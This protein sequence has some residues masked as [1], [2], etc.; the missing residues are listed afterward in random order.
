MSV[1]LE[2]RARA[3]VTVNPD[4]KPHS[5]KTIVP[6]MEIQRLSGKGYWA[7]ANSLSLR[8]L[9]WLVVRCQ[10]EISCRQ[11]QIKELLT[12]DH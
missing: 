2:M 8:L 4:C 12:C 9:G 3:R 11:L 6:L 1:G 7:G 10:V 5:S